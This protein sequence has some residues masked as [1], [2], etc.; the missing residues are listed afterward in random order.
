MSPTPA[1]VRLHDLDLMLREV[2]SRVAVSRLRR[3]GFAIGSLS[4]LEAARRV[5]LERVEPRWLSHYERA[6]R[7]YGTAV[8]PV[9]ARVCQGCH[10]TLPRS[11][12][13]PG[14]E[15]LTVCESCGR[16]LYWA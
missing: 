1:L 2:E 9:R 10:V 7:R 5:L 12:A 8:A 3:L 15:V 16:I 14:G 11:A 6:R 13:P 4:P